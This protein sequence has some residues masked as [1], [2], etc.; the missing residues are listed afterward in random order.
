VGSAV[1]Q[2]AL[3]VFG[4]LPRRVRRQLVRWGAPSYTVGALCVIRRTD[5]RILLVSQSYRGGWGLPGGLAARGEAVH[6][7]VQREV[8][9]EVGLEVVL[10]PPTVV[11]EPV[12]RRVDVV[13]GAVPAPDQELD[14]LV[15]TS[16]E[17]VEIAWFSPGGFPR[18][19][20]ETVA[21]LAAL[22]HLDTA[23]RD[24]AGRVDDV[25]G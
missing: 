13:F 4:K 9:E 16:P 18:L 10:G 2:L 1:Q 19:Q 21:A 6:D 7:A 5:G 14:R 11:V 15:S 12:P 23:T 25:A 20:A 24:T 22:E 17:I 8:R 3:R